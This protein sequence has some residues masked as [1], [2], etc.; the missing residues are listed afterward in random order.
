[1][2]KIEKRFW[3]VMRFIL[4]FSMNAF[5]IS[6]SFVLFFHYFEISESAVREAAPITFLNVI[7]LSLF[8]LSFDSLRQ[9]WMVDRPI[10]IINNGLNKIMKGEFNTKI[11]E[12]RPIENVNHFNSIIHQINIMCDELA[13]VETLRTDFITNVSHELK[14]PLAIIKNY[15]QLL[16]NNDL[17]D[18][19]RIEYAKA[20]TTTTQRLADLITNVLK[21]N[22]LDNQLIYS[23]PT[24]YNLSEQLCECLLNFENIWEEKNI[25]IHNYI[26]E[27]VMI[28]ADKELL[29]LVWNNLISNALKFTDYN[30]NVS[31]YL[32]MENNDVVVIINDNGCG[33]DQ[34]TGKHIFDKFYQGDSSHSTQGNGLGLALVKKVIDI[35]DGEIFVRSE[36]NKG[37][38]FEIRLKIDENV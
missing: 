22:K 13:G 32:Y 34:E 29:S 30:G 4:L 26:Q 12:L 14:T 38:Q 37:S 8:L 24:L 33:M 28:N 31:I 21:L 3:I 17:T 10:T 5:V 25:E 16:Q 19:E 23:E 35:V 20:I 18:E 6:C 36:L 1:M 11:E 27:N 9:K 7:I 2:N 15:G